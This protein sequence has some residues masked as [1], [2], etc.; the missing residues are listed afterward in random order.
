VEKELDRLYAAPLDEFVAER[1]ALAKQLRSDGDGEAADRVKA[2]RKP[3]AAV[4]A[5]NQLARRQQKDYRALLKAGDKLRATQEKVLGG[6]SPDKLQEAAAAERELV[7]RLTEKGGAVLEVA[8]H[9][10]TD[11]TLRRVSGTLHAAAT[12][13]DLR[14][15]AESGRLE[16][17]EETAGFGFELLSG[18]VPKAPRPKQGDDKRARE[19]REA[20]EQ[21]LEEAREELAA[22][23]QEAKDVAAEVKRLT[24]EL[25]GA[26]TEDD[27]LA[28]EVERR[29]QAVAKAQAKLDEL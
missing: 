6:E 23:K 17:E 10:P 1:D 9:K 18:G 8:G 14:E 7:D 19:R 29:E 12:R 11:A 24:R 25:A 3:S 27:R 28:K 22:A 20:A 13:P 4:W 2:L 16:H 15:A 5:V 26:S 21:R